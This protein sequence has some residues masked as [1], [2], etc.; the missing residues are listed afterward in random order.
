MQTNTYKPI[1]PW[2]ML[3]S[4]SLLFLLFQGL[5]T[6]LLFVIGQEHPW[7]ESSRWWLFAV[8]L[9][10]LVSIFLL[11][12]LFKAEGKRYLDILRFS[13]ATLGKDLL[14][15]F[16][17]SIIGLPIMAAPM[18]ILPTAIF[19]DSMIPV[20]MM[21][22]PLPLWALIVGFLFPLTIAFAELPTYFGYVMPRLAIQLKNGWVAWLIA[23]FFLGFQHI[24]LPLILDERFILYRLVLYLP[25]A[26]FAGLLLKLRP[27]LLPYFMVIHALIDIATLSTY[28]ML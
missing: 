14:W 16:G 24:F 2:L 12:R 4:R 3:I 10:N 20:N 21:F 19:G 11:V 6:L 28:W 25:F 13:K 15:F 22:R 26:L 23:S 9:A 7:E 5:I 27:S 17:S 1:T 18:Y 8:I